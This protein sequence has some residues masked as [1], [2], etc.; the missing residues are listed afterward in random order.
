MRH[1]RASA[2]VR[3][4]SSAYLCGRRH[5]TKR[6]GRVVKQ[7]LIDVLIQRSDKKKGSHPRRVASCPR[8]PTLRQAKVRANELSRVPREGAADGDLS[9]TLSTH[10]GLP[11][12]FI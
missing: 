1:A 7:P 6:A 2:E 4:E 10:M 9:R 11:H 8:R 3:R 5:H 12:N